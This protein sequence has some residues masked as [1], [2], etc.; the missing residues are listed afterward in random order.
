MSNN[1]NNNLSGLYSW[2]VII[3]ALIFF[4]PLGLFLII[5]RAS[6]DKKTALGAGK[7]IK[8]LGIASC[9]MA[10]LGFLVNITDGFDGTDVGMIIFFAAAGAALLYLANKIKKDA[11]S[12]KQ[13]LN[14]IV[15]GGERQLDAIAAATG[16]QYDVVKKD[17]QKMIDKG[18]L[19]NAYINENTREVVLPSA[20]PAN[21][22]VGQPTTNMGTPTAVQTR[23]VAC[24]CCGANN[25]VSGTLGECE[26]CGTPLK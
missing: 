25:T 12:V 17:V 5:K 15:N 21:T 11:D 26:Y 9:C 8:G 4:W 14:I 3:L 16:K 2:P 13:Y 19:K 23:V 1:N 24:P 20:A 6:L 7:L 22:N 10:A 18:F